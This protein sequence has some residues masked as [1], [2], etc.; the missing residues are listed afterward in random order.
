MV[1]DMQQGDW[2][3]LIPPKEMRRE[4]GSECV[5]DFKR[6]GEEFVGYFKQLAGLQSSARV[7]DVG[8]G[9]GRTARPLTEYLDKNAV[10]KGFDIDHG[11]IQGCIEAYSSLYPNFHFEWADVFSKKLNPKGKCAASKYKFPY[12]NGFFDFV[13]LVSLFTHM[14]PKAVD[15]Y[16]SEIRRVLK[17]DGKC[18]ITFFI[19]NA[20]SRQYIKKKSNDKDFKEDFRNSGKKYWTT[21]KDNPEEGVAYP[22]KFIRSLFKIH[23]LEIT[24][25]IHYGN[26]YG[27][28]SYLDFQDV[29]V[30]TKRGLSR[31]IGGFPRVE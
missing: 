12:E 20:E 16:F 10:Y 13:F 8:C 5:S 25:Q 27:R 11:M 28:E 30:A 22:E 4:V 2:N 6:I 24:E 19:I 1:N 31:H 17:T 26:W 29:V 21:N 7:L 9:C 18:L 23:Q 15:N 14:L 3:G